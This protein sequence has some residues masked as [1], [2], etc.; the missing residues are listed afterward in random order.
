MVTRLPTIHG[1]KKVK[2]LTFKRIP[3]WRKQILAPKLTEQFLKECK[4]EHTIQKED[5]DSLRLSGQ[6][7]ALW[8]P[9]ASF[10][11]LH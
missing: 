4:L 2:N 10:L 7:P 9:T 3:V 5:K 1:T 8:V 11:E 6:E